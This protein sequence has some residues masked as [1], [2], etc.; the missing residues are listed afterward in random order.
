LGELHDSDIWIETFGEDLNGVKEQ[1]KERAG[2]A[3][4]LLSHF[5][6]LHS[7]HLRNTLGKWSEWEAKEFGSHLRQSLQDS[8]P[9][10]QSVE[11]RLATDNK[12]K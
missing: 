9:A 2:A 7:K 3:L 6:R 11:P 4:W 1:S 10:V 8:V 12:N 5:V